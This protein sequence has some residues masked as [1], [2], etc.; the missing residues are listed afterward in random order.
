MA[1]DIDGVGVVALERDDVEAVAVVERGGGVDQ[2]RD[3]RARRR[4]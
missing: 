3:V 4:R 1:L 2:E